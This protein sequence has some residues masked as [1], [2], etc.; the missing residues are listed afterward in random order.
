MIEKHRG[1]TNVDELL[2]VL[3]YLDEAD[4]NLFARWLTSY[5]VAAPRLRATL[6]VTY[7]KPSLKEKIIGI[8]RG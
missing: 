3:P 4:K 1:T 8:L 5:P 2:C 7:E 6:G